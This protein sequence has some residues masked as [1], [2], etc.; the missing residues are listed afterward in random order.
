MIV[1]AMVDRRH[2]DFDNRSFS[3]RRGQRLG[4][5]RGAGAVALVSLSAIARVRIASR[6]TR[7]RRNIG[8]KALEALASFVQDQV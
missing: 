3:P 1:A 4:G 8:H 2:L 7:K 5:R 6:S